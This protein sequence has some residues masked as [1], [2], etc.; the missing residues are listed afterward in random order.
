MIY[1]QMQFWSAFDALNRNCLLTY[2]VLVKKRHASRGG[3]LRLLQQIPGINIVVLPETVQ[4]CGSAGSYM[5]KYPK[6][7]QALLDE[8]LTEVMETQPDYL[9]NSNIGCLLHMG[10]GLRSRGIRMETIHPIVL[11][12]RQLIV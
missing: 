6:M 5:L 7:A 1:L 2:A 4:C 3:A 8:L 10:A 9:V 12:A 11:F